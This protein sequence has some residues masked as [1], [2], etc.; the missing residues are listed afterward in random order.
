MIELPDTSPTSKAVLRSEFLPAVA[1]I[2]VVIGILADE[3]I[4]LL[5]LIMDGG[6]G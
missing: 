4:Y 6:C 3:S 5:L 1:D 2:A